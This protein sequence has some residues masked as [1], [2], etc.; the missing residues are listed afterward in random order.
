VP[1]KTQ[2]PTKFEQYYDFREAVKDIPSHRFLAIRRGESEGVLRAHI[3]IDADK[4]IAHIQVMMKHVPSSPFGGELAEAVADGYRRLLA[5]SVEN[6]V[7]VDLKMRSDRAAV[8]V[9]ADNFRNL[10]L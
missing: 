2:V 3:A 1:E 5:P 9:F 10:L 4:L 8:D 6:D 7:R